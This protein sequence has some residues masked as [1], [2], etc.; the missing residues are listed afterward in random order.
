MSHTVTRTQTIQEPPRYQVIHLVAQPA[1]PSPAAP[2]I[3]PIMDCLQD[4]MEEGFVSQRDLEEI[5]LNYKNLPAEDGFAKAILLCHVISNMVQMH[6][7][8]EQS[9][10]ILSYLYDCE[11]RLKELLQDLLVEGIDVEDFLAQYDNRCMQMEADLARQQKISQL[12]KQRIQQLNGSA[13]KVEKEIV[14]AYVVL[15]GRIAHLAQFKEQMTEEQHRKVTELSQRVENAHQQTLSR[16]GEFHQLEER[17][18]QDQLACNQL[19]Q[20]LR[21]LMEKVQKL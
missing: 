16:E 7:K 6:I 21:A 10:Q 1:L 13:Q 3:D 4:M 5:I 8:G 15:A 14:E 2:S 20:A 9:E 11:L 18:K 17:L 19:T 12:S